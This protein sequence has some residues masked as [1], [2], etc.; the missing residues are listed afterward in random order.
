MP[1]FSY[2]ITAGPYGISLT[3]SRGNSSLYVSDIGYQHWDLPPAN[4]D[5]KITAAM[6]RE[7]MREHGYEVTGNWESYWRHGEKFAQVSV[8]K[9][10]EE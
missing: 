5:G 2:M 3:R 4:E 9:I 7:T 8:T 10:S 6:L 1:T